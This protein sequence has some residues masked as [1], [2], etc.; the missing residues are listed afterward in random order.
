MASAW[1]CDGAEFNEA[2]EL[3]VSIPVQLGKQLSGIS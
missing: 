3:D 2:E 1:C